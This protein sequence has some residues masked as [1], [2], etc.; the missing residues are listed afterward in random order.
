MR[1]KFK[2]KHFLYI[3]ILLIIFSTSN[4][5][6][7]NYVPNPSF[8]NMKGSKPNLDP[9]RKVNTVDY[10]VNSENKGSRKRYNNRDDKNYTLRL[11]HSGSGYIGIRTWPKYREYI[12]VELID[13]LCQKK[14]YYFEMFIVHS[15][16]CNCYLKSFAASFYEKRPSYTS[17]GSI[18]NYPAQLM[19]IDSKGIKD[20]DDWVKISGVYEA[21]GGEKYLTIGNFSEQFK[22]KRKSSFIFS[23]FKKREAYYYV[24]DVSLY[25]LDDEG[26]IQYVAPIPDTISI[27][28][29]INLL[30]TDSL[31]LI[32]EINADSNKYVIFFD[33]N[34]SK[35][36]ETAY[37][38]LGAIVKH[39]YIN[40]DFQMKLY[41]F[42]KT[43]EN[44]T[45]AGA[46]CNQITT[47]FRGNTISENKIH[48]LKD[49]SNNQLYKNK[50]M[51]ILE[52][53]DSKN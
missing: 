23:F 8:D 36:T 40:T 3:G 11:P 38:T 43:N 53:F 52:I 18:K 29:S 9:W 10:F 24:D 14:K 28:D 25:P 4:I 15:P 48:I 41:C 50:A 21:S 1:L 16:F 32:E 17:G 34:S 2:I 35:I 30:T 39:L 22:L 27:K 33:K 45:I 47:F 13:T 20:N 6:A 26:N 42:H 46:R 7:Q 19:H 51:I 5:F 44:E 49:E 31:S 37:N 12:Q